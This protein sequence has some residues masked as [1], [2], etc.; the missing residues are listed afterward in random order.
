[1]KKKKKRA[2]QEVTG[3]RTLKFLNS[4][5]FSPPH[6]LFFFLRKKKG[7]RGVRG[8]QKEREGLEENSIKLSCLLGRTDRPV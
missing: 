7:K 2:P 6:L 3:A 8:R 4:L 5:I 1:M